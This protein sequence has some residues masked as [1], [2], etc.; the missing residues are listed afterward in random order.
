MTRTS[1]R[2]FLYTFE[3]SNRACS[4]ASKIRLELRQARL[5]LS[6]VYKKNLEL[7]LV[8]ENESP[9]SYDQMVPEC[10]VVVTQT[11]RWLACAM[12][13]SWLMWLSVIVAGE[14]EYW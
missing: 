5:D 2:F 8:M 11:L 14:V 3:R 10:N 7:V 13:V 12:H 4:N 1:S 6:N 9:T